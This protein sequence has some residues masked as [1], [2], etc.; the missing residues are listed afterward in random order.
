[1]SLRPRSVRKKILLLALIPILSLSGLYLFTTAITGRDA[2]DLAKARALK[3]ATSAPVGNFLG[4]VGIER[5]AAAVYLSAP[6]AANL[7]ALQHEESKTAAV[8]TAMRSALTSGNTSDNASAAER[9]ATA[10]L[11]S[12]TAALPSLRTEVAAKTITRQQAI[13][14]YNAMVTDA[15]L[16]LNQV[17]LNDTSAPVVTQAL[18]LVRM[19]RSEDTL[20]QENLLLL[21]DLSSR[22]FPVIDQRRFSGLVGARRALFSETMSDLSPAY[23]AFYQRDV[24]PQAV[25]ALRTMEN[26]IAGN[27]HPGTMPAV[28]AQA[29]GQAVR[30]VAA[31]EERAGAQ[32]AQALGQRAVSD[33][34]AT[35]LRLAI[36]GGVGL[37]AVA[38]SIL[39]SVLIGR[40]VVAELRRLRDGALEVSQRRLPSV[41]SR[42]AAGSPVDPS[43]EVLAIPAKSTEIAQVSDAFAEVQHTAVEAAVGQARVREG[44][45]DVFRNL[46]RRSQSLLHR[47]LTLIDTMER[48]ARDPQLLE[49]LFRVDHLT[50][51]MRRHAESL[52]LLSGHAPGRGWR[53]PVQMQ[54]VVRAAITEVEDYARV[55]V[56]V[57]PGTAL[58]GAA[59]GDVIH[60][61]A[62]LIENAAVFS[63]PNTPVI[64]SGDSVGHGYAVDI[65]DRGLGL[66]DAERA[67]INERLADPPPFDP[68]GTDQL[69]LFVAS[70][71]AIRHHIS[72]SLRQSPFGGTTA[73]VMIPQELVVPAEPRAIGSAAEG[74]AA[75]ETPAGR[76]AVANGHGAAPTL[77]PPTLEPPTPEPPAPEGPTP[78][79]TVPVPAAPA[80]PALPGAANGHTETFWPSPAPPPAGRPPAPRHAAP[81]D[82]PGGVPWPSEAWDR[83]DEGA[84]G[85]AAAPVTES[86]GPGNGPPWDREHPLAGTGTQRA[87]GVLGRPE[88]EPPW[89]QAPPLASPAGEAGGPDSGQHLYQVSPDQGEEDSRWAHG[90]QSP[91]PDSQ[92]GGAPGQP[93]R[94][95]D[96]PRRVRQASLAAALRD[97]V[98]LS[99]PPPAGAIPVAPDEARAT[100]SALQQGWERG[101]SVFSPLP[102]APPDAA[103]PPDP[104]PGP[105]EAGPP[106]PAAEPGEAPAATAGESRPI[107]AREDEVPAAGRMPAWLTWD[108]PEA[109]PGATGGEDASWWAGPV[110]GDGENGQGWETQDSD[111]GGTG[112]WK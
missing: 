97:N 17:I 27:P 51:R 89:D 106:D 85:P 36:S 107:P 33:A 32:A 14:R 103:G 52:I 59:V 19:A 42:L 16:L 67:Q 26:D 24:S 73:I 61:L 45:S 96:L 57:P 109:Q 46:A 20:Q 7:A 62:E 78:E 37:L 87:D 44:I 58:A 69:G 2:I 79:R 95:P 53:N 56:I 60:M 6:T 47:Q 21:G 8:V 11:L 55:K 76:P 98:P 22:S 34:R 83:R 91:R 70:Q 68:S 31:G 101:R 112:P 3:A 12:R 105:G 41:V 71:L 35:N 49:D 99:A 94:R 90:D 40:G 9:G 43:T 10:A 92:P 72:I 64:V 29:W 100:M 50:T 48:R 39:V 88:A 82:P 38:I 63:P 80:R 13:T 4:Q 93:S 23:R 75:P 104:A 108:T 84:F 5:L 65:E 25:T 77:E 81:Q 15:F 102:P 28:S 74:L 86:G 110:P 54:D 66:S 30:A 1:M 18:S 111:G